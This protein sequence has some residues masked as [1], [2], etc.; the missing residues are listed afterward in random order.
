MEVNTPSVRVSFV[1]PVSADR[2]YHAWLD[3]KQHGAFTGG[4]AVTSQP[5]VGGKWSAFDGYA[6][7]KYLELVEPEKI[8][9]SWKAED[10]PEGAAESQVEVLFQPASGGTR[11]TILHSD[12]PIGHEERF[13]KGWRR[14]YEASMREHFHAEP[15]AT[16]A[17]AKVE[18]AASGAKRR[19]KAPATKTAAAKAKVPT[20]RPSTKPR[21]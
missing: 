12:L 3:P 18:P 8:L 14:Y 10:F 4:G 1:L 16:P 17:P 6:H 13:R 2:L 5:K 21:G 20:S 11:V 9:M 15:G 19:A 7:G